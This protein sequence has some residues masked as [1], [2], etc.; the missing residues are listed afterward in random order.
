MLTE[1]EIDVEINGDIFLIS[2]DDSYLDYVKN[3]FEPEMVELFKTLLEP[4]DVV[5]DIGANIGCTALLFGGLASQVYAFEPSETTYAFLNK[6]VSNSGLKNV[7]LENFGLGDEVGSFE[8]TYSPRNRSG[9]FVSNRTQASRGHSLE[10]ISIRLLDEFVESKGLAKVDLIKIDVE[11]FEAHVLRGSREVLQ[12]FKPTVVLELNHWCL[13]ALQRTSV[14]DFLD[15]L[16]SVF[17]IL[18]AV[19]GVEY[20]DLH[21]SDDNYVVMYQHILHMRFPNIVAC[22]EESQLV[23]FRSKYTH[24][25][26]VSERNG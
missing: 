8:L 12:K 10:S 7:A 5:L 9:G 3:G 11:G 14:P 16:R 17:P 2:S 15:Y 26:N 20:L 18:L 13:N 24:G 21:Q 4:S 23:E 1:R 25:F 19:D 22:F 6:N